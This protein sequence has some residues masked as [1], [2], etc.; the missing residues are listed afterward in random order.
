MS[1]R[2]QP[3]FSV[4]VA[5]VVSTGY[6]CA[7]DDLSVVATETAVEARVASSEPYRFDLDQDGILDA[8]L[9]IESGATTSYLV[10]D[11]ERHRDRRVPIAD[12]PF[13]GGFLTAAGDSGVGLM[14]KHFGG[15]LQTGYVYGYGADSR[16]TL[17][18]VDLNREL[19]LAN[20]V[21][22]IG[23]P[24][25]FQVLN[26]PGLKYPFVAPAGKYTGAEGWPDGWRSL[27]IFHPP[28]VPNT[29]GYT[30]TYDP[31]CGPGFRTLP[32][33]RVD[34][35]THWFLHGKGPNIDRDGDGYDDIYHVYAGGTVVT[36]ANG[37]DLD[38]YSRPDEGGDGGRQYASFTPY[39]ALDG[40]QHVLQLAADI[41]GNFSNSY[42]NV[43]RYATDLAVGS[44]SRARW[45]IF[46]GQ[47]KGIFNVDQL[48][49]SWTYAED[50]TPYLI[51]AGDLVDNCV[52]RA[53]DSVVY[54]GQ[55][56]FAFY[57]V[58][59]TEDRADPCIR[60]RANEEY[61]GFLYGTNYVMQ[62][63]MQEKYVQKRG[64]WE[65]HFIDPH[66]GWRAQTLENSYIWG[67]FPAN[68][69]TP[70]GEAVFLVER[71]SSESI[72][73]NRAG[74]GDRTLEVWS[75]GEGGARRSHI[76]PISG[77][78]QII[79][80]N[81]PDARAQSNTI[82][83]AEPVARDLD[84]DGLVE[85]LMSDGQSWVGFDLASQQ[86]KVKVVKPWPERS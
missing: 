57:S 29:D 74:I 41:V 71:F 79:A 44:P 1:K 36:N 21:A 2:T 11:S 81:V 24:T 31:E 42:C 84:G 48:R 83:L 61:H 59:R 19:I 56:P 35:A 15:S 16:P 72:P 8:H 47:V 46:H 77:P 55:R 40:Q 65:A 80:T 13:S 51:R 50:P 85:V 20:W 39:T 73:F 52:H 86:F 37:T 68:V 4:V 62:A 63:C 43:T 25:R 60:E 78:P 69:L 49:T 3:F 23:S 7:N 33:P 76:L 53:G 6:G 64:R 12:G 82:G 14:G 9:R 32:L 58:F 28:F 27:C 67:K 75:F 5:G 17:L 38:R 30:G 22:P 18:I 54:A 66:T 70:S 34:P 10:V 26:G 45:D